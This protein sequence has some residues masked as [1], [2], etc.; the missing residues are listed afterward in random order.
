MEDVLAPLHSS[1]LLARYQECMAKLPND[2]MLASDDSPWI[3]PNFLFIA[4]RVGLDLAT[5]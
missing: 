4:A 3:I 5:C 2:M 1:S